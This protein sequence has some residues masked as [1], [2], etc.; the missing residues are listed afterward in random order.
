M[1]FSPLEYKKLDLVSSLSS[2][3]AKNFAE[4]Q[5]T[6]TRK[7]LCFSS[8]TF[9]LSLSKVFQLLSLVIHSFI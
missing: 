7:D 9:L 3:E 6:E 4:S 8:L 1:S 5:G 2:L